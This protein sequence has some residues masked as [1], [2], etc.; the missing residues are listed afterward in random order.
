[1]IKWSYSSF[2]FDIKRLLYVYAISSFSRFQW[3]STTWFFSKSNISV[4]VLPAFYFH[5]TEKVFPKAKPISAIAR[6][7][8]PWRWSWT[9]MAGCMILSQTV[10][11]TQNDWT[12]RNWIWKIVWTFFGWMSNN[13]VVCPKGD[14]NFLFKNSIFC[15]FCLS[16]FIPFSVLDLKTGTLVLVPLYYFKLQFNCRESNM[17]KHYPNEALNTTEWR[18][19]KLNILIELYLIILTKYTPSNLVLG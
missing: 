13:F 2:I 10:S 16:L 8:F 15:S 7:I 4:F 1:M 19:L 17:K 11:F 6:V 12:M 5:N 18:D 14:L 9:L 3:S